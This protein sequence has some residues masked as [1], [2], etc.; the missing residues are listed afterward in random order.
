MTTEHGYGEKCFKCG[1][2]TGP[3]GPGVHTPEGWR[4][5]Q[6]PCP[7]PARPTGERA[8][9]YLPPFPEPNIK[10]TEGITHKQHKD[11][12]VKL[13]PKPSSQ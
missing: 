2:P 9:P 1:K 13:P 11:R 3:L 5:V 4:H 12:N 6:Q 8:F 10:S 7:T